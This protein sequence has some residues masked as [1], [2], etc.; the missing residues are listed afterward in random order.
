MA[1]STKLSSSGAPPSFAGA[2]PSFDTRRRLRAAPEEKTPELK[3][4]M[5]RLHVEELTPAR[6]ARMAQDLRVAAAASAASSGAAAASV[7]SSAASRFYVAAPNRNFA[8]T[9]PASV[10]V[11]ASAPLS[12]VGAVNTTLGATTS[13]SAATALY[14]TTTTFTGAAIGT[15][16]VLFHAGPRPP[17]PRPPMT[18]K[19]KHAEISSRLKQKRATNLNKQ[20]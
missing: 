1:S 18:S 9:E 5:A 10:I 12:V 8:A 13:I 17:P 7:A 11:D 3:P 16:S 20:R 19:Q 14:P 2:P 15:D 6:M 4:E